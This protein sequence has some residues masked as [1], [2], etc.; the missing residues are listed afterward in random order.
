LKAEVFMPIDGGA[1]F[2]MSGTV[3][4]STI[5]IGNDK[6]SALFHSSAVYHKFKEPWMSFI[7]KPDW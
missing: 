5:E 7:S 6:S 2:T 4:D 1:N 3:T